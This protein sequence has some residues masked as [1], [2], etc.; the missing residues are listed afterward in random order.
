MIVLLFLSLSPDQQLA[1]I[2]KNFSVAALEQLARESPSTEAGGQ[3]AAWR[4]ALALQAHDYDVATRWFTQA[5]ASA[6]EGRRQ[7]ERGLGDVALQQ[8][9]YGDAEA[10]YRT[11]SPG[12]TGVLAAELAQKIELAQRLLIRQ[13]LEWTAWLLVCAALG[14]FVVRAWRG[15]GPLRPP[16]EAVYVLPL[17]ALL[18]AGALGRDPLVVRALILAA[19]VS[20][21]FVFAA[22]LA[23]RRAPPSG[24]LRWLHAALVVAAN[25]ALFYAVLNRTGLVDSLIMTTQ[26]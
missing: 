12:A 17:Y 10:H 3:A 19:V 15:Q 1:E 23:G 24:K 16:L 9:R 26:M 14:Y 7:G 20:L 13:R 25:L 2:R 5:A 11:A 6:G 22:G 4:G 21:A 18:I 8:R